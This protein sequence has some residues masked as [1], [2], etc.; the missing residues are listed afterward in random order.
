[1]VPS[2]TGRKIRKVAAAGGLGLGAVLLCAAPAMAATPYVPP[3]GSV[4]VN[5]SFEAPPQT[6]GYQVYGAGSTGIQGWT[7]G[8][9][10]VRL[11]SAES[12]P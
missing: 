7:V 1:M 11:I 4:V 3:A 9:G 10:S 12:R 5:G 6:S 8:S 2:M